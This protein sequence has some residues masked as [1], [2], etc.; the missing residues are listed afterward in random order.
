[1]PH[2]QVLIS[3]TLNTLHTLNTLNTLDTFA[4]L[5]PLHL[6]TFAPLKSMEVHTSKQPLSPSYF[7]PRP[8]YFSHL[9]PSGEV[10]DT[11]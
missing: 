4:P 11:K 6:C 9:F 3:A 2:M 8:S 1:M 7:V 10:P 5:T